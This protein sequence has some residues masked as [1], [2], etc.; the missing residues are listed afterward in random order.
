[1]SNIWFTSDIHVSHNNIIKYCPWNRP[2]DNVEEMDEA[3]INMWNG[4]V[5]PEDT[6][7]FMGDFSLNFNRVLEVLPQLNGGTLN[8]VPG[9][10]DKWHPMSSGHMQ[11]R[12]KLESLKTKSRII[13]CDP[14]ETL[15]V[16]GAKFLLCHFPWAGDLDPHSDEHN[17]YEDRFKE[18]RPSR[19]V[20]PNHL[21][22]HGHRHSTPK[23]RVG[24]RAIDVGIDPWGRILSLDEIM[25]IVESQE[26]K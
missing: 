21:L 24:D 12:K 25:E 7:F 26:R 9:N 4:V 3:L 16:G 20:Y 22:L 11:T 15:K 1:M 13:L 10:H 23:D 6:V 17:K 14:I 8:L 5:G 2:W 18:W 19:D